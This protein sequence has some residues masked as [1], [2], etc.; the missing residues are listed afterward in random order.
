MNQVWLR[1]LQ[2]GFASVLVLAVLIWYFSAYQLALKNAQWLS[3]WTLFSLV[4][5]LG[6][7]NLRKKISFLPMGSNRFW[8]QLHLYLG[9]V[10]FIVFLVHIEWRVPTGIVEW[11]LALIFVVICL[12]G[13]I[14]IW[15]S[16]RFSKRLT[17]M[18]EQ[19][20]FERIPGFSLQIKQDAEELV[21]DSVAKTESDTLGGFYVNNLAHFFIKPRF[22]I[23]HLFQSNHHF[24]RLR[25]EL[26]A[27]ER[28]MSEQE[29]EYSREMAQLL[30]KK[31]LLDSQFSLQCALKSW[32]FI[33]I[34]LSFS[35]Y[36]ILAAHIVLVYG[37][38]AV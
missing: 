36:L 38:G 29:K 21:R 14:G 7:Y 17:H 25:N 22:S 24:F 6:L 10:A 13:A 15:M 19:L 4:V 32:L 30:E 2:R 26:L 23:G 5:V 33:H 16:R 27:H 34:P 9:A 8:L 31:N 37:F 1:R 12:S 18:G 11:L 35:M 3:G 20:L 28:Y